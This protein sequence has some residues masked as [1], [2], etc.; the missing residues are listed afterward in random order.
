MIRVLAFVT[1]LFVAAP[2]IA[3]Q[4]PGSQPIKIVVPF[5]PG[6]NTDLFGR[7]VAEHLQKRMKHNVIVENRPGAAMAIGTDLVAKSPADGHTIL[8]AAADL[9]VL[10][11][12]RQNLPYDVEKL[13][14]LSRIFANTVLIV[15]G[16]KS[17]INTIEELI[18]K[19]RANPG[20]VRHATN[21]VGALNHLGSLKFDA[22]IGGKTLAVPYGGQG[23]GSIDTVSGQVEYLNGAG[24]PLL[25]GLKVLAPS[26]SMRHPSFPNLPTLSELGYKGAEW[27]AWFGF[28]APP[29][30]PQPIAERLIQEINAVL[31]EPDVIERFRKATGFPPAAEPLTGEAFRKSALEELKGWR[32]IAA[33]EKISLQ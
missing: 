26:G 31:K 33:R 21:G 23:P 12:V 24:M 25:E 11:A 14:Y 1:A 2:A 16:P 7:I 15:T 32:E 20:Q 13:T 30:L 19:I 27:D 10:P 4:F 29:N 22:A 3:Q 8:L 28:I 18:A 17:G 6:G 9:V 5:A